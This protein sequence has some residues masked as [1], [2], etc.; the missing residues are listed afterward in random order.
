[1]LALSGLIDIFLVY[2]GQVNAVQ[3]Y[4]GNLFVSVF[5]LSL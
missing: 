1:M 2:L 3:R 5:P 4:H